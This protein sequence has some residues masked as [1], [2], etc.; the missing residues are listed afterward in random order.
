MR[1]NVF[2][3]IFVI[4]LTLLIKDLVTD[5]LITYENKKE[6]ESYYNNDTSFNYKSNLVLNIPSINLDLVVKKANGDFSNLDKNL[7]YYKRNYF[8]DKII[9][10][11]HSGL[12]YGAFFNR[13]DELNKND[14]A[15]L[16]KDKNKAIYEVT[17]T[18]YVSY[19][20]VYI[21]NND[22]EGTLLLV[23]CKKNDKFSR[24]VVKLSLKSIKTLKK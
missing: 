2:K 15:Y 17:D 10:F 13:L 23:T 3:I 7:V 24:L 8:H 21:L 22:E 20:D 6:V 18:Y 19:K 12:G 1:K 4:V 14:K 9:I 5:V 11:G 16:Y